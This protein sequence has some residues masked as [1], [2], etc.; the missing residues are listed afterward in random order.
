[1]SAWPVQL[2]MP[3]RRGS[4]FVTRRLEPRTALWLGCLV[5]ILVAQGIAITQSYMWAAPLAC[6]LIVALATDLPLMPFIGLTL[7]VRVLTDD[8]AS[9][10]SRHSGSLNLSSVTAVLFI[11]V[12]VGLVI[13]RRQ[14]A[15][16][17]LLAAFW[18][19]V[20]TAVAIKMDG[21][22]TVTVREG[23]REA[24]IVALGVIA[25]NSRGVLNLSVVTRLI[26]VAGLLSAL[27][28]LYQ[29]ATHGG[30]MVA[31]QL[32]SNGTFAQPNGAAV[33][34]AVATT[35]SLW[36][37]LEDGRRRSDALFVTIFAAAS[38]STFSLGGLACLLVM[39]TT[40]GLLRPG[41]VRLKLGS[42]AVAGLI[43]V[44][45]LATPLG[46]ERIASES[47]TSFGS[48]GRHLA[49]GSSL[50]WRFEK[51]R[52]LLPQWERAP[53]FGQGLGTTT[54]SEGTSENDSAALLPHSEVVRFLVE[55][56]AIGFILL[57][58][59]VL[60]VFRLLAR[61]RRADING[62]ATLGMALMLGLLVNAVASN[63]LLYTAAAYAAV[64]VVA[65]I[66]A[67]PVTVRGQ[68]TRAAH[69]RRSSAGTREKS[70]LAAS[71]S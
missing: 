10:T 22:S 28:A 33:F 4:A 42:C 52:A 15:W 32:R 53:F 7:L 30:Q 44:A 35:V 23:V 3:S 9:T 34:F 37:F 66:L 11:L 49:S 31:G 1:M 47:S 71:R 50:E 51:W 62:A 16:P 27:L 2:G 6:I 59:G 61:Q 41:S 45:F 19:C 13:R 40:F 26:Q 29:L 63:T 55:T 69:L 18:L 14:A 56:G 58:G 60:I 70:S 43:I 65:S 38:I 36:R 68:K 21:A 46:A 24:S 48:S 5:C 25:F 67:S 39:L 57:L 64:L 12:A 54:T 17:A 20:W 8:L